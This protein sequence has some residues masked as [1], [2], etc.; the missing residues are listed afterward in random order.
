MQIVP[1]GINKVLSLSS[2][3]LDFCVCTFVPDAG[4]VSVAG[5]DIIKLLDISVR[6]SKVFLLVFSSPSL[7]FFPAH[8]KN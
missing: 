2:S 3:C 5:T 1:C 4:C 8:Q 7:I 6:I